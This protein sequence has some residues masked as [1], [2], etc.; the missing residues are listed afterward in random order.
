MTAMTRTTGKHRLLRL[1]LFFAGR[2]R[3][4]P[5]LRSLWLLAVMHTTFRR[6]VHATKRLLQS[7]AEGE[8]PWSMDLD[9]EAATKVTEDRLWSSVYIEGVWRYRPGCSRLE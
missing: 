3:P 4:C 1:G 6:H 7:E 2:P 8:D 5:R 9:L